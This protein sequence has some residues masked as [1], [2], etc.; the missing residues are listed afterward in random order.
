MNGIAAGGGLGLSLAADVRLA[1]DRSISM[2]AYESLGL[3][4]DSGTSFLLPRAIGISRAREMSATGTRL[5]ARAAAEVGLV[6]EVVRPGDLLDA[7]GNLAARLATKPQGHMSAT[8]KLH[9]GTGNNE[10]R[11]H[12]DAERDAISA[13]ATAPHVAALIRDVAARA[14][15]G[16]KA[17]RIRE[18]RPGPLSAAG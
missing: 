8:R 9:Q 16:R 5:D 2:T 11:R 6:H 15:R 4:L 10:Y 1:S 18:N 17:R 7:A 13:A 14:V 12:L 3:T